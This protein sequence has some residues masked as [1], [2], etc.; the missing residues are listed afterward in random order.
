MN[1]RQQ[2]VPGERFTAD[3]FNLYPYLG[4]AEAHFYN[5]EPPS[6]IESLQP[7]LTRESQASEAD[8]A[9]LRPLVQLGTISQ[10]QVDNRTCTP[11]TWHAAEMFLYLFKDQN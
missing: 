5:S 2:H 8:Y 10:E 11:H 7:P 1:F 9:R 6:V 3:M 4:W